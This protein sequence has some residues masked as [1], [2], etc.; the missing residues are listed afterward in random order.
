MQCKSVVTAMGTTFSNGRNHV[1]Q[2]DATII[3]E[4]LFITTVFGILVDLRQRM[5]DGYYF[6]LLTTVEPKFATEKIRVWYV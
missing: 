4:R 1:G 3:R 6:I 5:I 2:P